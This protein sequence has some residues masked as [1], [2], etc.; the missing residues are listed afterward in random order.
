MRT[1]RPTNRRLRRPRAALVVA[2]VS[3]IVLGVGSGVLPGT[4]PGLFADPLDPTVAPAPAARATSALPPAVAN[5]TMTTDALPVA[6]ADDALPTEVLA[7]A[8]TAIAEQ[9]AAEAAVDL[10]AAAA[11]PAAPAFAAQAAATTE[12]EAGTDTEAEA[13]TPTRGAAG[14]SDR[15][16]VAIGLSWTGGADT[17]GAVRVRPSGGTWSRWHVLEPE[18]TAGGDTPEETDAPRDAAT[19]RTVSAP[20]WVGGAEEWE[21]ALDEA[22]TDVRLHL[23][24]PDDAPAE[25]VPAQVVA[26]DGASSGFST[27][28]VAIARPPMWSRSTWGAR[29]ATSDSWTAKSLRLV[30]LH[31]TGSGESASYAS[32]DVP[33][34]MRAIQAYHIDANGWNDIGYNFVVDR[35]GA[36]WE[37]RGGGVDQLVVGAH[38]FGTNTGSVGIAVLGDFS[39]GSPTPA[40][41]SSVAALAAWKLFRHGADPRV[42]ATFLPRATDKFPAL[43]PATLN[44]V[45]GHRDVSATGCPGNLYSSLAALRTDITARYLAMVGD[46]TF[47]DRTIERAGT[48]YPVIGDF[49]GDGIADVFWYRAGTT[50]DELWTFR[51]DATFATTAYNIPGDGAAP[52]A[53]LVADWDGDGADDLIFSSPTAGAQARILVGARSGT[54]KVELLPASGDYVPYAGD[55][56][57]DGDDDLLWHSRNRGDV[58]MWAYDN[59]TLRSQ[60]VTAMAGPYRPAVGDFDGDTRDDVLWYSPGGG[61]DALWYGAGDLTFRRLPAQISGDFW[62]FVADLNGDQRDDVIWTTA[63]GPMPLWWGGATFTGS[64][65]DFG[66]QQA[67]RT[68]DVNGGGI[69]DVLTIGYDG[70]VTSWLGSRSG[71]VTAG[72]QASLPV[73]LPLV[74]D[75]NGDGRTDAIWWRDGQPSPMWV[76]T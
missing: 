25:V 9:E 76:A 55:F 2:L 23:V 19:E 73:T 4:G 61:V 56:N 59:G 75:F 29:A 39:S 13:G 10:A 62:P 5:A 48:G 22:M 70:L 33:A 60:P 42:P 30:V 18:A 36:I 44:R 31:H 34:M 51:S 38:A 1:P 26:A 11:D 49:S 3:T 72:R 47:A 52:F 64:V 45:I 69:A 68:V 43:Q 41:L 15:S 46:G 32:S 7:G 74:G 65:S 16:F 27:Q 20:I 35:F 17:H 71:V 8:A 24:R 50:P 14:R 54:M 37:G 28:A 40:S 57:G 58:W 63:T 67:Y 21:L 53:T 6:P 66:P 12:T